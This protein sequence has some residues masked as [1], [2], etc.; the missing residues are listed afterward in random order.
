V[1]VAHGRFQV[2]GGGD[3]HP[4]LLVRVGAL[5]GWFGTTYYVGQVPH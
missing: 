2:V 3:R 5:F 4:S 1:R